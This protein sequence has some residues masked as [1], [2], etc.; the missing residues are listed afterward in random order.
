MDLFFLEM[1]QK[2]GF[3]KY[4]KSRKSNIFPIMYYFCFDLLQGVTSVAARRN[5]GMSQF[6]KNITEEEKQPNS[7]QGVQFFESCKGLKGL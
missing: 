3:K 1:L 5:A 2:F 6:L 4:K 7:K